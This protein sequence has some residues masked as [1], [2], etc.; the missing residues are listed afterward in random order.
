MLLYRYE[1]IG[2]VAGVALGE[3]PQLWKLLHEHGDMIDKE[4]DAVIMVQAVR[5]GECSS[6]RKGVR[7]DLV[8]F[9][10]LTL[11][12]TK[13]QTFIFLVLKQFLMSLALDSSS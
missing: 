2:I 6:R 7:A 13:S 4:L 8:L 12:F 11:S 9:L 3:L 10:F 5:C 1:P